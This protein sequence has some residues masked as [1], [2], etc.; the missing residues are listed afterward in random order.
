MGEQ[1]ERVDF[2]RENAIPPTEYKNLARKFIPGYEGL[3][4]LTEV[5]LSEPLHKGFCIT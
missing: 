2:D 4:S 1:K 3:Y 5:L